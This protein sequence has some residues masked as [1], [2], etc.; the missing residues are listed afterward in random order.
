[1]NKVDLTK[2]QRLTNMIIIKEWLRLISLIIYFGRQNM[3][4]IFM[5]IF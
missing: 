1:M 5:S 4:K 2:I 3:S